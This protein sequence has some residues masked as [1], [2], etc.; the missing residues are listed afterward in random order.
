M[1]CFSCAYAAKHPS[2]RTTNES[3][4]LLR[5]MKNFI[6]VLPSDARANIQAYPCATSSARGRTGHLSVDLDSSRREKG[7]VMERTLPIE[8]QSRSITSPRV[9]A[10][11]EA[12]AQ[13][14]L[15]VACR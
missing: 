7:E 12:C 6:S 2:T 8:R 11:L 4:T 15:E 1:T 9:A 5:R 14:Q 3:R 10:S 13:V